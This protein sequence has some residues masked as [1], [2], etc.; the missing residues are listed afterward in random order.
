MKNIIRFAI[1]LLSFSAF[2]QSFV[3]QFK[4]VKL[5][6]SRDIRVKLPASFK[7]NPEKKYPLILVL[8]SEYLYPVFEGNLHFGNYWDDMP[9]AILVGINQNKNNQ[10]EADCEFDPRN[11]LPAGKGGAFF[12]FIGTELIP[13]LEKKYQV[14][15]FK[16]IAGI[17]SSA[18]LLNAFLY[19]EIPLFNAYISLSPDLQLRMEER[20]P[21]RLSEL[22]T[23]IYYYSATSDGDLKKFQKQ[24]KTLDQNMQ[25]VK[26][27]FVNY[28]FDDFKNA[29]HYTIAMLGIPQALNQIFQVYQPISTKEYQE[30]IVILPQ[31]YVKYL[32]D[33]YDAIE[34]NLGI[35]MNV[36]LRDFKAI[37][38]AINK[39][40]RFE[41]Y[42]Q[43]AQISGQQYEKTMMYDYHMA[44]YWEKRN[45]IKKAIKNYE[46]AFVKEEIGNLTK[47]MM[48]AKAEELKQK[49]PTK[50]D[51]L[52]GGKGKEEKTEEVI[53]EVP[54][55]APVET[56]SETPTET[57]AEEKKT[58]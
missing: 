51:K 9:E 27:D 29:N 18:A 34:K 58:E 45:E 41:E 21:K 28:K 7:S 6:E 48:M 16:T 47:A 31:D 3:E 15:T 40:E 30:K 39:N 36:R 8:D 37:E 49:M 19:K 5:N 24:I 4:S 23:P 44:I 20:I 57:P 22:Q 33:K 2:S 25:P 54:A 53:E 13:Y 52:K 17:D 56:P 42:E 46:N 55:D 38:T 43:L 12:E 14:G 10:R 26:N 32:T 11:G 1:L 50:K 35:K